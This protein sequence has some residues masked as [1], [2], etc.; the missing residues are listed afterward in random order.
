MTYSGATVTGTYKV[1]SNHLGS[2]VL[3]VNT[4]DGSI[5]QQIAYDEFGEVLSD[6]NPGFT[7][8]GFAGGIYDNDTRLTRFGARDYDAEVGRWTSKDPIGFSGGDSN[9]YGYVLQDPV[10]LVDVE[11]RWAVQIGGSISGLFP[12]MG[13]GAESGIAISYSEENG[14]QIAGYQS[15]QIRGGIGAYGGVGI[16]ISLTPDA[17]ELADLS[18]VTYGGGID[19]PLISIFGSSSGNIVTSGIGFGIGYIGDIY[20][21]IN[22]THIGTVLSLSPNS[23]RCNTK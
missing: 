20:G 21:T 9:L 15:A 16:N 1:V 23:E 22:Y 11:G 13:G 5:A 14:L 3:V 7:P 18:G 8:F 4:S 2:P 19:T 17:K 6:T 12:A 10:N